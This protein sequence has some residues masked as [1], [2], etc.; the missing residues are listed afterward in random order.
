MERDVVVTELRSDEL[1]AQCAGQLLRQALAM[2][3][4]GD[5]VN[6]TASSAKAHHASAMLCCGK[7]SLAVVGMKGGR[8]G[9]R[10]AEPSRN[11][12]H[13]IRPAA[14]VTTR[15][16]R[17]REWRRRPAGQGPQSDRDAALRSNEPVCPRSVFFFLCSFLGGLVLVLVLGS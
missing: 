1:V 8:D 17:W 6:W 13:F 11:E 3:S 12:Q 4:E 7:Q 9:R 15:C 2:V 5:G 14:S 16:W 10:E